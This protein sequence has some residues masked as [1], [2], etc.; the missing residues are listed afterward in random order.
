MVEG[1]IENMFENVSQEQKAEIRKV[2][3]EKGKEIINENEITLK[4]LNDIIDELRKRPEIVNKRIE[5]LNVIKSSSISYGDTE[6]YEKCQQLIDE[7]LLSIDRADK[8]ISSLNE[9]A[10]LF[11]NII[12]EAKSLVSGLEN[13]G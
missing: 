9:R 2:L 13:N 7:S 8:L 1:I 4:D 10:I 12:D 11:Q 3:I 6:Q 5:E